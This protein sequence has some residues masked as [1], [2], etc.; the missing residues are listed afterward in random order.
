MAVR[1]EGRVS[2]STTLEF[3]L[4]V[5]L[6]SRRVP[7]GDRRHL[8]GAG[9][10]RRGQRLTVQGEGE[11]PSVAERELNLAGGR[12]QHVTGPGLAPA[13]DESAVWRNDVVGELLPPPVG[14]DQLKPAL[15]AG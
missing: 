15:A 3:E 4:T 2:R 12:E 1:A 8:L 11:R 5:R 6:A 14:D 10:A 9:V 7:E 13:G